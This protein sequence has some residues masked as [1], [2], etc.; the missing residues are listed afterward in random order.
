M[1]KIKK[2][3]MKKIKRIALITGGAKRIGASIARHLHH[4]EVDIMIHHNHSSTDAKNL[5]AELNNLRANSAATIQADLLEPESYSD[6]VKEAINIFGQLDFLINNAS[7]YYATPLD[8]VNDSN[9]NDLIGTNLKAPLLMS[10]HAAKYLKKT[11][12]S[13]INITD[14]QIDNPKKNYIIYSLAKSG[15]TTLTKSLA[16]ELSP[17][18]RVNAVA[19]GAI[20]WPE[21]NHEFDENYRNKVISQ[22]LLKKTGSP[23]DISKAVEFLLLHAPYVTGH[24]LNVDGGRK[25]S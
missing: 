15:L 5:M 21:F 9:W 16:K 8:S 20:L 7:T 25:F 4:C 11:K 24:T 13:I 22:T 10:K 3:H 6:I 2:I 1:T 23:E 14:A 18:I 19:P 17:E 12:G